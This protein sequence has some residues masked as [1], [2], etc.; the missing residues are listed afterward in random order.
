MNKQ[1]LVL[2]CFDKFQ[3]RV[4][5][6]KWIF[7][8][9]IF[10]S[11]QDYSLNIYLRQQWTDPRLA[12]GKLLPDVTVKKIKMADK[13]WDKIWTPDVFFRNEKRASF[14]EVTTPNRLMSLHSDGKVWYV[15]K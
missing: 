1:W 2:K 11:L 13:T 4:K 5:L 8:N 9:I 14:H 10:L 7:Q 3:I 15:T 12:Y 6:R